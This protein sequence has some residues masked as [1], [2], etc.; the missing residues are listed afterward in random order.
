MCSVPN[1]QREIGKKG[2]WGILHLQP[3]IRCK[4]IWELVLLNVFK[5]TDYDVCLFLT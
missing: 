3:G 4:L 1:V 5:T 2:F